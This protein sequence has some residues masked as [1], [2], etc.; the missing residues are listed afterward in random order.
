[1]D[2]EGIE[3]TPEQWEVFTKSEIGEIILSKLKKERDEI[4]D[5]IIRGINLDETVE[6]TAL[7][8]ALNTGKIQG[9]N[10]LL[11]PFVY[12]EEKDENKT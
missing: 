10:M 11:E 4:S 5:S 7:N 9:I 12:K 3:L 1:M 6:L 8:Y 2:G